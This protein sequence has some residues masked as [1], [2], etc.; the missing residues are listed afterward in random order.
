MIFC[1]V[2]RQESTAAAKDYDYLYLPEKDGDALT[3]LAVTQAG[4]SEGL[5]FRSKDGGESWEYVPKK[6]GQSYD[7]SSHF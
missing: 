4:E 2:R 6:E 5:V 1:G 7:Q 3:V